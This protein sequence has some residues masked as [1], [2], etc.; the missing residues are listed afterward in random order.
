M[1]PLRI[2]CRTSQQ[3]PTAAWLMDG[4]DAAIWL[5][6]VTRWGVD[7][8]RCRFHVLPRSADDLAPGSVLVVTGGQTPRCA[9]AA[10][11]FGVLAGKIFL[12][13]D[14]VLLPTA[15]DAE[16]VGMASCEAL[17]FH[18]ALGAVACERALTA[19][20]LLR[21]PSELDEPF[22][23]ARTVRLAHPRIEAIGF[24]ASETPGGM[25]GGMRDDIGTEPPAD[26]SPTD[27]EP[28][29]GPLSR[30]WRKLRELA[31]RASR[32]F[33]AGE[34]SGGGGGPIGKVREWVEERLRSLG[35]ELERIRNREIHRLLE[36]L[37]NDP[38]EAL[39]HALPLAG[40]PGRGLAPPSANLGERVPDFNL[41]NLGGGR[42]A[43]SW[44]VNY[45]LQRQLR[46]NY[47]RLAERERQLGRFRRAAYIYAE[48]LGDL[49]SAALVLKEGH[50]WSEAALVYRDHLHKA[51]EAARCFVEARMPAE[52]VAIFEKERAWEELGELHRKLG[53][54]AAAGTAFRK[55]VDELLAA[56]Q[57]LKAAEVL[58]DRLQS[59]EAA[60][61]LLASQ[62]PGGAMAEACVM[63]LFELHGEA[64]EHPAARAALASLSARESRFG[65]S[66]SL[67]IWLA[68]VARRYPDRSVSLLSEDTG[69]RCI[70]RELPTA[71]HEEKKRL[72]SRLNEFGSRDRLLPRDVQRFLDIPPRPVPSAPHSSPGRNPGL[73]SLT[74]YH[75]HRSAL[76]EVVW[77][78]AVA[79]DQFIVM[80]GFSLPGVAAIRLGFD[81]RE[82][83][84]TW[85]FSDGDSSSR[86]ILAE[87]EKDLCDTFLA[88]FS[89]APLDSRVILS[90]PRVKSGFAIGTPSWAANVLAAATGTSALWLLRAAPHGW[91]VSGHKRDG[92]LVGQ[93]AIDATLN[94]A[95][96]AEMPPDWHPAI[97][98]H[99]TDIAVSYA[100][101]LVVYRSR[102]GVHRQV[103]ECDAPIL[104]LVAAPRWVE[105]HVAVVMADR[106]DICWLGDDDPVVFPA[107]RDLDAQ[108]VAGFA[109]EGTL[110][111]IAGNV[112][113]LV[114][115]DKNG[116]RKIARFRW[117]G[118][119]PVAV[120]RGPVAQT[121]F[122]VES[123]GRVTVWR[124]SSE[125]LR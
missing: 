98:A 33:V 70:A 76:R 89:V 3:R 32:K 69:R 63:R 96:L 14:A 77:K 84:A 49:A 30:G 75:E 46:E 10:A 23:D 39:R 67:L 91:V 29:A 73:A 123:G 38:D 97:A 6:E 68:Y 120:L 64:G 104:G 79:G 108:P 116:R 62:W 114:E 83:L 56:R 74:L 57:P 125:D 94:P 44:N 107:I 71:T 52:A 117:E 112:G 19:A 121:F 87:Q 54:P 109:I 43:D 93:F 119:V 95:A 51:I 58:V 1:R 53:D 40:P 50:H 34:G 7:D 18:P 2:E 101:V 22:A 61:A 8:S 106:V 100:H 90:S 99:Q 59:R 5:A 9:P 48:L 12:P 118:S 11:P 113:F 37:R 13:V 103:V 42:P 78:N 66:H 26:L 80:A 124:F 17:V 21:A 15:T 60:L 92:A 102:P 20:D 41:R 86:L 55:W 105:P 4:G 115:A 25:F 81:W 65:G 28:S 85:R 24:R 72:V 88:A 45:E 31:L 122:V 110:V 47:V 111:V 27:D 16:L 35:D 82:D 36:K